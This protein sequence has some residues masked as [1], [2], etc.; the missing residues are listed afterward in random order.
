MHGSRNLPVAATNCLLLSY[1]CTHRLYVALILHQTGFFLQQQRQLQKLTTPTDKSTMLLVYL[2]LTFNMEEE[3]PEQLEEPENQK[4]VPLST[5]MKSSQHV[6]LAKTYT[7]ATT[8]D[9]PTR[10][11]HK[12]PP[13]HEELQATNGCEE[14]KSVFSGEEEPNKL[15]NSQVVG[16]EH[17]CTGAALNGLNGSYYM[18]TGIY[19]IDFRDDGGMETGS[20]KSWRCERGEQK[21][22]ECRYSCMGS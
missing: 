5:S 21:P 15:S 6:C 3:E 17:I 9:I 16:L 22:C 14:R 20:K 8:V 13:L 11:S 2:W 4:T 18:Y 10:Q 19:I 7:R 1:A 12:A